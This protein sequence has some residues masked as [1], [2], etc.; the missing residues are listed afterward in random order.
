MGLS[1][2]WCI[3]SFVC[4]SQ[5]SKII[6]NRKAR[7]RNSNAPP[8]DYTFLKFDD[9]R[10][11]REGRDGCRGVL[12]I[13]DGGIAVRPRRVHGAKRRV[14]AEHALLRFG[15]LVEN[16][17]SGNTD[18]FVA[19]HS[20][21]FCFGIRGDLLCYA[22][23]FACLDIQFAFKHMYGAERPHARLIVFDGGKIV[24]FGGFQKFIDTV[25][26]VSSS[27]FSLLYH[28]RSVKASCRF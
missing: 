24:R 13:I 6:A 3:G 7:H 20:A 5:Y 21:E 26:G 15:A 2:V 12:E 8:F 16:E 23:A 1:F 27:G 9:N 19:L 11:V 10:F 17:R 25:H 14:I 22:L 28:A 4:V 18:P